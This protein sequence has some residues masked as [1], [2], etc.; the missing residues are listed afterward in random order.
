M[1]REAAMN[2][3][4]CRYFHRENEWPCRWKSTRRDATIFGRGSGALNDSARPAIATAWGSWA[5]TI[6]GF[7]S[8]MMRDSFHAADR[9]T[10]LRGAS[11]TRSGPSDARR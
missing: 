10:S 8:R 4:T 7:Q 6:C 9:S 1:A 2:R 11:G 5:C 3:S